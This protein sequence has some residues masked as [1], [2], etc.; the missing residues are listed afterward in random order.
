MLINFEI[1]LATER[2]ERVIRFDPETN[3]FVHETVGHFDGTFRIHNNDWGRK[4]LSYE[5]W[6]V[7]EGHSTDRQRQKFC[8]LLRSFSE[9]TRSSALVV[10]RGRVYEEI[11]PGVQMR[12]RDLEDPNDWNI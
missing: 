10:D 5:I 2:G 11:M 9:M 7:A 1:K 3:E 6:G 8:D 4:V 12:R